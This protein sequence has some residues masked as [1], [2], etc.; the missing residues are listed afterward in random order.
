MSGINEIQKTFE[1]VSNWEA[2]APKMQEVFGITTEQFQEIFNVDLSKIHINDWL[3]QFEG[4][5]SSARKLFNKEPI[6]N[7]WI[8][9]ED[10]KNI[11]DNLSQNTLTSWYDSFKRASALGGEESGKAMLEGITQILKDSGLDESEYNKA[12]QGLLA[13]DWSNTVTS[14]G[15]AASVIANL[16]GTLDTTTASWD[17]FAAAMAAAAGTIPDFSDIIAQLTQL[18]GAL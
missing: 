9:G 5:E 7:D 3:K 4:F 11:G 8:T 10:G 18:A 2:Y 17:A 16:G 13:I 15:A 1:G 6:L 14:A 12:M